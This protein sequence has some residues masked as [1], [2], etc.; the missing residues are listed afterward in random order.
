MSEED[1]K[2]LQDDMERID[3]IYGAGPD[4][5]KIPTFNFTGKLTAALRKCSIEM[6]EK[7]CK[8]Q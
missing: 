6:K 7:I 3:R 8:A 5:M 2:L 1:K 4:F